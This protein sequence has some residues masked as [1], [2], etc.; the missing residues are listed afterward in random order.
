VIDRWRLDYN[1]YH[2]H[3]ALKVNRVGDRAHRIDGG[4]RKIAYRKAEM[5]NMI[6]SGSVEF[7]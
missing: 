3:S 6:A 5:G 7:S 2:I 1:H 4:D